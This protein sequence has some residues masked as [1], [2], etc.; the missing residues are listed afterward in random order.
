MDA[1]AKIPSGVLRGNIR[2]LGDFDECIELQGLSP[3]SPQFCLADI[4]VHD[5]AYPRVHE[6]VERATLGRRDRE[7]LHNRTGLMTELGVFFTLLILLSVTGTAF[8]VLLTSESQDLRW[9]RAFSV[10]ANWS[11]LSDRGFISCLEGLRALSVFAVI[12]D[13]EIFQLSTLPISNKISFIKCADQTWYLSA[14]WAMFLLAPLLVW[15]IWRWR[16]LALHI[17]TAATFVAT[18]GVF[19]YSYITKATPTLII[20]QSDDEILHYALRIYKTAHHRIA[21]YV[22]GIG[23]GFAIHYSEIKLHKVL[24][25]HIIAGWSAALTLMIFVVFAGYPLKQY[26]YY[27]RGFAVAIYGAVHRPL[28]ALAIAWIVFA[29]HHGFGGW[30]NS[31]LSAKFW[32]PLSR[33]SLCISLLNPLVLLLNIGR[34]RSAKLYDHYELLRTFLGDSCVAIFFSFLL[35]LLVEAPASRLMNIAFPARKSTSKTDV[36]TNGNKKNKLE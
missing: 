31:F 34:M 22:I 30:I 21:A 8:D 10:K 28:W 32:L 12:M 3:M 35:Y 15:S 29:C 36:Y 11:T 17:L 13:H 33:I 5:A 2:V 26:D 20:S 27:D 7:I 24:L 19:V 23:L 4:H 18:A 1:S 6:L 25:S 9:I 14:D 16:H